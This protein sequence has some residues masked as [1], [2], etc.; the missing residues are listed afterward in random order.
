MRPKPYSTWKPPTD[1]D[2][3]RWQR[4]GGGVGQREG[5]TWRIH[6]TAS[7]AELSDSV[8]HLASSDEAL[9]VGT[10]GRGIAAFTDVWHVY[11]DCGTERRCIL[12]DYVSAL[13]VGEDGAIWIGTARFNGRGLGLNILDSRKT[14][15]NADDDAW[16][17]LRS[18]SG[19][20]GDLI[21]VIRPD[22]DASVWFGL[23]DLDPD[24][25][26]HGHGLVHLGDD[27]RTINIHSA[28]EQAPGTLPDNDITAMIQH[29]VT[30]E[31]WVGT[32]KDGIGVRSA[33][34]VWTIFTSENTKGGLASD[35]VADMVVEP[36]GIVWVACREDSYDSDEG[37]WLD[38]GLS[39]FDGINWTTITA[40][41]G[42]PSNHLSAL[43]LDGRGRL[44]V[45][46][47]ATDRGPKEHAFRG[48]GLAAVNIQ[49]RQWERSYS[50]PELV[51]N[52]ITDLL[53][54]DDKLIAA[55]SYFFY[56]DTRPGGAQFSTGGG[57]S[58]LDLETR[59]WTKLDA[60]DG[61]S[62]A[63]QGRI[64]GKQQAHR[65]AQPDGRHSREYC[66]GRD[67][68]SESYVRS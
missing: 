11:R 13:A 45:G 23:A 3:G 43:A 60:D 26:A 38:G 9:W 27:R 36:G 64:G 40:N 14:P 31:L 1:D 19:L 2:E 44:W 18:T 61:L 47:G 55:S 49:T 7:N 66:D 58:I 4:I 10:W 52:N 8:M 16:Y 37:R 46:T 57:L 33:D 41:D 63:V 28:R 67:E 56:V 20:P 5:T 39:R 48:W 51:S 25:R 68:L 35:S 65:Y 6:D 54:H 42:L 59:V 62:Y 32:A 21:N 30:E 34:G 24:N 15:A 17:A 22:D 12:S 50:F 53:V 29:P